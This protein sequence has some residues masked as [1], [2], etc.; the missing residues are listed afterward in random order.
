[1]LNDIKVKFS[2]GKWSEEVDFT[3]L[4]NT[5]L[6]FFKALLEKADIKF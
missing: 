5:I 4:L 2:E 3:E 1:M 6:G